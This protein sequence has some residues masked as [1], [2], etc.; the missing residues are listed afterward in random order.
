MDSSD[1]G[2]D[3]HHDHDH[4]QDHDHAHDGGWW[5]WV[6]GLLHL[7]DHGHDH[8]SLASETAFRTNEE[9]IRTVWIA[10]A[11]LALTTV[12]QIGIVWLSGSVALLADTVH[13]LG[14]ALNSLPLLLAFYLGRRAATRR[15]N[16]G[17]SRAEDL[18][19]IVIVLSIAF[20]AGII[21]WESAQKF[22]AL[23]PVRN[24][25]WVV[26][27]SLIGFA[28]NE[29]VA[30][31]QIRTGR[32]IGSAA[33]VTDGLHARTDGLTSLAVLVAAIGSWLGFPI[34]DPIIGLLIGVVILFITRDAIRQIW[35]RL[36]D[37]VDPET[38]DAAEAV[39][40]R[41]D[42][43]RA[44]H[45]IRMRWMGHRLHAEIHIAVD[46]DL[47]TRDAHQIAEALRHDLFHEIPH[48]AEAVV[49]VDPHTDGDGLDL[50]PT[51]HHE[52]VPRRLE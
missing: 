48:L 23:A 22:R 18:A 37:A 49:H 31:L 5:G 52:G 42:A 25:P 20:S 8:A 39:V 9:G 32:R 13:N 19:G 1:A 16:Y 47:T 21:F 50:H 26:A 3:H 17:F 33:L 11:L 7:G 15:Y 12:I 2:H 45:R 30:W 6:R 27:A 38:L 40:G 10:L 35:Y 43:V 34:L 28:G 36:M 14:D 46:P 41:A 44:L 24:V 4:D 51:A 29:A